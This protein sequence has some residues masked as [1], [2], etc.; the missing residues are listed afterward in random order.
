[1]STQ[2]VEPGTIEHL[3]ESL[4]K[5]YPCDIK[6]C[7]SNHRINASWFLTHAGAS[8]KCSWMICEVCARNTKR[9][10]KRCDV[11]FKGMSH[12]K[13]CKTNLKVTSIILRPI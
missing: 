11:E 2:T 4:E 13:K 9:I 6:D 8:S 3:D 10:L 12:C 7:L 5:S 1:M